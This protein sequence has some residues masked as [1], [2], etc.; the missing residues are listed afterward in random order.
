[1]IIIIEKMMWEAEGLCRWFNLCYYSYIST[2]VTLTSDPLP[3]AVTVPYN[4]PSIPFFSHYNYS[5]MTESI[6]LVKILSLDF[7]LASA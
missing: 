1:M 2:R 3:T 7:I 6:H 4:L 5:N